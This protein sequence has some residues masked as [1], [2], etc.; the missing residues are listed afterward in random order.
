MLLWY[1]IMANI[2]DR[3]EDEL[4]SIVNPVVKTTPI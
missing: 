1:A 3:L 4:N 2:W